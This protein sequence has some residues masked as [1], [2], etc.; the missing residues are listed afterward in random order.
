MRL[1]AAGSQVSSALQSVSSSDT[2]LTLGFSAD[3]LSVGNGLYLTVTGR[4]VSANNEYRA[5]IRI[6]GAKTVTLYLS[7]LV[8]GTDTALTTEKAIPGITYAAGKSSPSGFR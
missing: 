4:Q 8:N 1:A 7:R 5:R 2:D 3:K 6:T